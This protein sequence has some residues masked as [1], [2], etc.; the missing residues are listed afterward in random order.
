MNIVSNNLHE[1]IN[2]LNLSDDY[3]IWTTGGN[4]KKKGNWNSRQTPLHEFFELLSCHKVGHK[5]GLSFLPGKLEGKE[6]RK[7]VV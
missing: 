4:P 6:E 2:T 7:G 1:Q 5:E 3:Q